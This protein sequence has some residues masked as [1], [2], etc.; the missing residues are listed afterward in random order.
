M[1][2]KPISF[3]L[4]CIGIVTL[5]ANKFYFPNQFLYSDELSFLTSNF[6][7]LLVFTFFMLATFEI[8]TFDFRKKDNEI[9]SNN[10][11]EST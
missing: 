3:Y 4:G 6:S 1:R 8:F 2:K 10:E 9:Q 7:G 11:E 5:G